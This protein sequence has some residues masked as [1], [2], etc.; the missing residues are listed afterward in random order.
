MYRHCAQSYKG[1][2]A[3]DRTSPNRNKKKKLVMSSD[4]V[5]RP[6]QLWMNHCTGKGCT[7]NILQI[8]TFKYN[9]SDQVEF[10]STI[11]SIFIVSN[12]M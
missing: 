10:T 4:L 1:K 2:R 5:C 8:I 7:M 3:L 9:D 12:R 11:T 6:L